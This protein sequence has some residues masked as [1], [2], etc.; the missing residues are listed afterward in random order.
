MPLVL[1]NSSA[2]ELEYQARIDAMSPAERVSRSAAM[3]AWTCEQLSR[4]IIAD[5]GRLPDEVIKLKVA[6]RLYGDEPDVRQMIERR[7]A[8]VSS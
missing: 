1:I 3:F 2:I 5:E 7:L 4:Q 6:L 8:N